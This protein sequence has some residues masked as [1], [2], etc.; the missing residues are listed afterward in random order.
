MRDSDPI[1]EQER[2]KYEKVWS[3]RGYARQADG[4]P[5]V[6]LAFELMGCK[7]GQSLID[8]G[9]GCGRPAAKFQAKGLDVV[10]FDIASNCLDADVKIPLLVRCLWDLPNDGVVAD[11]AFSTDVLEHIPPDHLRTVMWNMRVRT[12]NA[13][14][15]QVCTVLD[16][17]GPKMDPPEVLHLSVMSASQWYD[18]L[19]TV[20]GSVE[21]L[22]GIG[23][24]SRCAF[25]CR[26]EKDD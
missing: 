6:D 22:A 9:C 25:L 18:K 19:S 3:D 4:D 7:R 10:G 12:Y 21:R 24:K 26:K 13:A 16:S 20:W 11:Y 14:F 15:I 17:S 1:Q 8:W 5:V 2:I 23:G